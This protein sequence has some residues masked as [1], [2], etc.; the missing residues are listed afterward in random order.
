MPTFDT[1]L[2]ISA[3]IRLVVGDIR[4]VGS[5]RADTVIAVSPSDD[6]HEPDI[7]AAERTRVEY[8]DGTLQV[9]GTK[10]W[11]LS[12]SRKTGSVQVSIELPA[13]SQ[14]EAVC[15]LGTILGG[16]RLGECRLR[17]GAGDI[18]L[19]DASGLDLETGLGTIA[20]ERISGDVACTTASGRIRIVAIEGR[21]Q[22]KNS[23]GATWIGEAIGPLRVK[24][25]NGGV[26]VDHAHSDVNAATANGDVRLGCVG[27]GA[28]DLK[29]ALGSIEVGIPTGTAALLD[30][31]TSF[32]TVHNDMDPSAGPASADATVTINA[33]TSAG[34]IVISRSS[35]SDG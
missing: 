35:A 33:Q 12:P 30:L 29:T 23:N 11:G 19:Q 34:D 31:H 3:S 32:G 8:S 21:A 17:T 9:I 6:R 16:G 25:A 24:A 7:S 22:V 1:P 27:Q 4:I 10:G 14:V 13:G 15:G 26:S 2:P 28:V 18:R 20:A 5:D